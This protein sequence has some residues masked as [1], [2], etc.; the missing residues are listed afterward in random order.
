MGLGVCIFEEGKTKGF[1][2]GDRICTEPTNFIHLKNDNALWKLLHKGGFTW[3]IC[4]LR[5]NDPALS[6]DFSIAWIYNSFI[7][8]GVQIEVFE[9]YIYEITGLKTNCL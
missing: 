3:Y 6:V 4:R 7:F 2:G 5:G 9:E 8:T 1:M